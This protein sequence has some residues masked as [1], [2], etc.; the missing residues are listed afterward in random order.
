MLTLVKKDEQQELLDRLQVVVLD[1]PFDT[2][3]DP[4]TQKYFGRYIAL[5]LDGFMN[6]YEK[7]ILPLGAYDFIGTI[8]MICEKNGDELQPITC[9][10]STTLDRAKEFN[11]AFELTHLFHTEAERENCEYVEG[12]ISRVV[13]E[14][15][16]LG[17]NSSWTMSAKWGRGTP[18]RKFMLNLSVSALANYYTEYGIQEVLSAGVLRFKIDQFQKNMGFD[19]IQYNGKALPPMETWFAKKEKVLLMHLTKFSVETL[20]AAKA[21]RSLWDRRITLDSAHFEKKKS[22]A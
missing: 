17:Y 14:G 10:K 2:F 15:K 6:E 5:K 9:F 4:L 18:L 7:G 16:K 20:A 12:L 13:S 1:C 3:A 21:Y 8:V 22:A 11:L 19:F